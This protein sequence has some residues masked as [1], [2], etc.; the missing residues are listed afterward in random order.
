MR[1][2]HLVIPLLGPLAAAG[3]FGITAAVLARTQPEPAR[4]GVRLAAPTADGSLARAQEAVRRRPRDDRALATLALAAL[5]KQRETGDPFWY[6]TAE[7]AARRAVA[8][9]ARNPE[10]LDALGLLALSRHRFREALHWA[11]RSRAAAP[12]RVAPLTI[13][14]DALVE[15]GR[16][17]EAFALIGR[18]LSLRPDLA[19]YSRASYAAE[20]RGRRDLAATLMSLAVDAGRPGTQGRAWARVQLGLLHLGSGRTGAAEREM[21]R[22]LAERPGDPAAFAG[23]ARALAARGRLDRAAALLSR[24]IDL[25][26]LPEHPALLAEIDAAR[27]RP[28]AERKDLELVRAMARLLA[29]NGVRTDL[30]MAAILADVRRPT[31]GDVTRARRARAGRPGVIGDSVLAWVLTRAG[32]CDEA[33]AFARRSLRLGTRDALMLFRAGM[34][35]RCAG[36]P[37]EAERRLRSALSL[38]PRFSVR[39]APVARRVLD[40]VTR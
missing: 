13:R 11:E 5:D 39:W 40:E 27:G 14:G 18:R 35:A 16:Y 12:A 4:T 24:A 30:D 9:D 28:G 34:A 1:L 33:L 37:D 8:I 25:V 26:P 38:N 36:V 2:R 19:S 3:I 29:A 21:R 10:A 7:Q 23:L 31:A 32:R 20:L 17:K 15:L 22:A 6:G